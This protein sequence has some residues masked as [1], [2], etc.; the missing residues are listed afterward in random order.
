MF[1]LNSW[2]YYELDFYHYKDERDR[3]SEE[4]K[5]AKYDLS[6]FIKKGNEW[7]RRSSGMIFNIKS[8]SYYP[9]IKEYLDKELL[10]YLRKSKL[11]NIKDYI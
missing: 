4:L 7:C 2:G 1:E 5:I 3:L 10:K 6:C 11:E 8:L 9:I